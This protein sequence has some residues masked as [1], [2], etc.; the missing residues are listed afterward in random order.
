MQNE[1][2]ARIL[3]GKYA[4][5]GE[6]IN[7]I[8][9]EEIQTKFFGNVDLENYKNYNLT[10]SNYSAFLQ[11]NKQKFGVPDE[12]SYKEFNR[13]IFRA[14]VASGDYAKSTGDEVDFVVL[15]LFRF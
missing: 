10:D 8:E 6:Y 13:D 7:W 15:M 5:A 3:N 14:F 12:V 9:D 11:A 2:L 1:A 4:E